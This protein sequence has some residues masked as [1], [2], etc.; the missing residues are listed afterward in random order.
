MSGFQR[1]YNLRSSKKSEEVESEIESEEESE[2]SVCLYEDEGCLGDGT[3]GEEHDHWI[4]GGANNEDGDFCMN[5]RHKETKIC[6]KCYDEKLPKRIKD[7]WGK[8]QDEGFCCPDCIEQHFCYI[9]ETFTGTSLGDN[10]YKCVQC[11]ECEKYMCDGDC[12]ASYNDTYKD[13]VDKFF[14]NNGYGGHLCVK[15]AE[16]FTKEY[17]DFWTECED[18][19]YNLCEKFE[20]KKLGI[21]VCESC[22]DK[23]S[24]EYSE[25]DSDE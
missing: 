3:A 9:C 4:C 20:K 15:C 7:G 6:K 18:C 5:Y 23:E 19:E 22:F 13:K 24:E 14:E 17:P 10:N 16:G 21:N 2:K 8:L 1:K 12:N 25:T 11:E